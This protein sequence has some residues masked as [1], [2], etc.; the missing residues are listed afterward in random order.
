MA[1]VGLLQQVYIS[2]KR[3]VTKA[4]FTTTSSILI[5]GPGCLIDG[6]FSDTKNGCRN[7]VLL[8]MENVP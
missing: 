4:L 1:L 2:P 8:Y 3:K 7:F 6:K 5:K